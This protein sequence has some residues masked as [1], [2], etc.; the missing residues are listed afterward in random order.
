MKKQKTAHAEKRTGLGILFA[1]P[2]PKENRKNISIVDRNLT[3]ELRERY[4][5]EEVSKTRSLSNTYAWRSTEISSSYNIERHEL[6]RNRN[7]PGDGFRYKIVWTG[8]SRSR[9]QAEWFEVTEVFKGIKPQAKEI[10]EF[11]RIENGMVTNSGVN[12]DKF[13]SGL[14]LYIPCRAAQRRAADKVIEVVDKKLKKRSYKDMPEKYG[15]GTLIVGLPLWFAMPPLDPLRTKNVIDDF[16]TRIKIGLERHTKKLRKKDCPFWRIVVI[17]EVSKESIYEWNTKAKIDV[18]N[19]PVNKKISVLHSPV[20]LFLFPEISS[21]RN[22]DI[23]D[24]GNIG[25]AVTLSIYNGKGI[26]K[27]EKFMQSSLSSIAQVGRVRVF[28][29]SM[30]KH[31]PRHNQK[32]ALIDRIKLYGI[33]RLWAIFCFV[34]KYHL[35]GLKRWVVAK[36]SPSCWIRNFVIKHRVLRLYKASERKREQR[37]N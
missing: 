13:L 25:D 9:E 5:I 28:M 21:S 32:R 35:S 6:G 19:D 16:Y 23:G 11:M 22:S 3:K 36:I 20:S 7:E 8:T 14:D 1:K 18:Y 2:D 4:W 31:K 10:E 24:I 33:L 12:T 30:K 27:Q 17:W 37:K 34:R 29:E 26:K 15:Y